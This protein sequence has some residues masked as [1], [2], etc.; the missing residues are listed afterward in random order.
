MPFARKPR[1]LARCLG[2]APFSVALVLSPAWSPI[3]AQAPAFVES[4]DVRVVNVE[5]VVTDRQGDRVAGL[6]RNDFELL[7]DGQPVP[8]EFFSEVAGGALRSPLSVAT[9]P[10]GEPGSEAA[11][12]LRTNVVLFIDDFFA[13]AQDR[14]RALDRLAEDLQHLPAGDLVAVV[15]FN[16]LRL[17]L[18]SG[19]SS[20]P[21]AVRAALTSARS[22]PAYGMQRLSELRSNDSETQQRDELMRHVVNLEEAARAATDAQL[23]GLEGLDAAEIEERAVLEA[24]VE[25]E[26]ALPGAS[27]FSSLDPVQQGYVQRLTGQLERSVLAAT[28]TLRSF[29]GAPGRRIMLLLSGGWPFSP[30]EYTLA[31]AGAAAEDT[32]GGAADLSLLGRNALFAPLADTANLLGYTLYPVDLP[33]ENR[34]TTND[35][36]T[37]LGTFESEPSSLTG[38]GTAG[39]RELQVHRS[40]DFL[41]RQTGGRALINA[42]RDQALPATIAD[43]RAFYWLGFTPERNED[44]RRHSV[45]IRILRAG[46]IARARQGFVDLSRADEVTMMVESAL[47][48]G[49]PPSNRPLFLRFGRGDRRGAGKLR[50]P[51]EIGIPMDEITLLE[52]AGK[53]QSQLEV[54]FTVMD[55][56]GNRSETPLERVSIEGE[57]PPE[58][59]QLFVYQT[60]LVL[61]DRP[62]RLVVAV[63]D[64]LSG[65]I[66]S[67]SGELT[68]P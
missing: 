35:A 5:V 29:A 34:E 32:I 33:G 46:L 4:L 38:G 6:D 43:T 44:G 55:A 63:H 9:E 52:H 57:Q 42:E 3:G 17:D 11:Q 18:L 24:E 67:A 13:I 19:W 47:L 64:P 15:A 41:A 39:S 10:A 65:T 62:H 21:D 16:G 40:L 28:S 27:I 50:L 53:Y 48:F 54:R 2:L 66:L 1:F 7:V 49:D 68:T 45:E 36:V 31:L 58:P 20:D 61:R 51:L 22:R 26:R 37:Q 56:A 14:N 25:V 59:G 60:L 12:R 30:A 23:G 8:I